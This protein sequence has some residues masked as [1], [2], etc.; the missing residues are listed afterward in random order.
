MAGRTIFEK[1]VLPLFEYSGRFARNEWLEAARDVARQLG[2][3][4]KE[5]TIDMVRAK[6]PPPADVDP[7]VMGAVFTRKEWICTGY[8]KSFRQASHGRPVGKF[9]L[10]STMEKKDG[11]VCPNAVQP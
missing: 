4:G 5:T 6:L 2:A 3:D 11:N 10:K 7:R 8:T 9:I 1:E